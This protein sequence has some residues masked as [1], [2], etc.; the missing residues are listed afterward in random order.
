MEPNKFEEDIKK[1]LEKRTINPSANSW[2]KL[3]DS[4]QTKEHKKDN[5]FLWLM[6]VAASIVGILFVVSIFSN[7]ETEN[8]TPIIVNVPTP[9]SEDASKVAT[10]EIVIEKEDL[11]NNNSANKTSEKA[12]YK[13]VKQ[14]NTIDKRSNKFAAK[15]DGVLA[16]VIVKEKEVQEKIN[17]E[18]Q[19][20]EEVIAQIEN[21]K[22]ENQD[23]EVSEVDALL[24]KAQ[25]DLA[26]QKIY[27]EN[28]KTVDAYK[29]LQD[30]EADLDKSLRVKFLETLKLNYENMKT[31][32]AQRND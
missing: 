18:D 15:T 3:A 27:N 23:V 6:G 17:L 22:K 29:L 26:F 9:E 13:K 32:I 11:N 12:N 14:Q 1:K 16:N 7:G 2:N 31:V 19:K 25:Q 28:I 5:R 30:V 21:L 24:F 8:S 4:L 20:I 10:E